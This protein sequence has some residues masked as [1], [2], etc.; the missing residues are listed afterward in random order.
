M[1]TT[2]LTS[3]HMDGRTD[4]FF[5][6]Q[7]IN[8]QAHGSYI[9]NGIQVANFMEVDLV[10]G[11]TVGMA[12]CFCDQSVHRQHIPA[13]LGRDGKMGNDMH[14][15]MESRMRVA[16]AMSVV[17]GMFVMMVVVAFF[18]LTMNGDGHV[19]AC[20]AAFN[21]CFRLEYHTRD[22]QAIQLLYKGSGAG[23]KLQQGSCQHIASRT[24]V[25]FKIKGFP[26]LTLHVINH[27]GKV[28]YPR[29]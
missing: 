22:T 13:N 15:V 25:T 1:G 28:L 12:F 4:D 14:N 2:H 9:R 6:C 7:F 16:V 29:H 19:G 26:L 10:N 27:T 18:F 5:R 3:A 24:H 11:N 20:D 8:Q 17:M 21:A 23:M